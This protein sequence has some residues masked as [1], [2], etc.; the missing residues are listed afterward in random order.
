MKL[1]LNANLVFA[2]K[3]CNNYTKLQPAVLHRARLS[4]L[5][6][7]VMFCICYK[8]IL[9]H[10]KRRTYYVDRQSFFKIFLKADIFGVDALD[11]SFMP[12]GFS[13]AVT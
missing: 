13:V 5:S 11:K 7:F 4:F 6:V 10:R 3:V 1:V 8:K 9:S 2:I 12:N